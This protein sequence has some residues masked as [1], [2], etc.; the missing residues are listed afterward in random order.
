MTAT[1]NLRPGDRVHVLSGTHYRA[2]R[3][4]AGITETLQ[5]SYAYPAGARPNRNAGTVIGFS[6]GH[7]QIYN[8]NSEWVVE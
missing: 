1:R 8:T 7:E 3:N 5:V 6:D 2:I 4:A